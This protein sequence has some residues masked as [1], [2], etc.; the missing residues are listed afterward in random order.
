MMQDLNRRV[1]H[2]TE[3]LKSAEVRLEDTE[4]LFICNGSILF[5]DDDGFTSYLGWEE[6]ARMKHDYES[7][8][9]KA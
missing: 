3:E 9:E 7:K 8:L 4:Y 1:I 5:Y 6:L 2:E